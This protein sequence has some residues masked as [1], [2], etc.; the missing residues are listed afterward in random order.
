[1]FEKRW[2]RHGV[3]A[4][5]VTLLL[6]VAAVSGCSQTTRHDV[7][8]FFFTGVPEPGEE[9][10]AWEKQAIE[11]QAVVAVRSARNLAAKTFMNKVRVFVHGP[12]GAGQCERCHATAASKPFR[13][14]KGKVDDAV[15]A[16]AKS[17][18]PRL[19]F[20]REELCVTCH[21]EKSTAVARASGLWQHEPVAKGWCTTCHSPHKSERQYMLLK[22]N[23][24]ELCTQCHRVEDLQITME[25]RKDPG[26]ECIS[27]HN[28]HVGKSSFLLKAEYDEWDRFGEL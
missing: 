9:E 3:I 21:S 22:T 18:G 17:F 7:L 20:P 13:T 5:L 2:H 26:A 19:A 12:Y 6:A 11:A 25:H 15:V 16:Q 23:S 28:P 4:L 14:G 1:M 24:V 27:C 8:T 10:K